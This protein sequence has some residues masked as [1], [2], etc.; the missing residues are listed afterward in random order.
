MNSKLSGIKNICNN[1]FLNSIVQLL[2][3]SEELVNCMKKENYIKLF[4]SYLENEIIDPMNFLLYY[5]TIHKDIQFG[6]FQ[7]AHESLT[8]ILDDIEDKK[9][10]SINL[11]KKVYNKINPVSETECSENI[12]SLH[13]KESIQE[14][15]DSFFETSEEVENLEY[16]SPR[17]EI[18][19]NSNPEFLFLSL[20]RF[21][22][23]LSKISTEIKPNIILKYNDYM[24]AI[25]GFVIHYG[26]NKDS[27]HYV[28]VIFKENFY[29][30]NDENIE[31][32]SNSKAFQLMKIAYIY[33]YKKLISVEEY[34]K[35][36]I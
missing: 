32:I 29:L 36:E 34:D 15:L 13:I 21:D 16:Y 30:F 27:G 8:M 31:I 23:N 26:S 4:K 11:K 18:F 35:M 24:Y 10:F 19:P 1:C 25:Q 22:N 14:S 28:S 20:N 6:R 33:L 7:D 2:A 17:I 5:R 9:E 12:L 3:S